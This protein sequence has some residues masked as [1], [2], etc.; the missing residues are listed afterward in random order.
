MSLPAREPVEPP[1]AA[2]AL[3]AP[4]PGNSVRR[5][6]AN[7]SLYGLGSL[8]VSTIGFALDPI[9][10]YHLSLQDFGLL[11]LTASITGMLTVTYTAGLDG[12]AGR[13]FYDVEGDQQARERV[14]GTL[15]A[16]LLA[17]MLALTV[18]QELAGPWLYAQFFDGLPYRPYGRLLAVALLLNGLTAIPRSLWA[19]GE[20]VRRLVGVR[21]AS[22]LAGSATLYALLLAG[23]GPLAV[24]WADVLTPT[25]T[26]AACLWLGWKPLQLAW[27]PRVLKAGLAFGLPMIVHL[28]SHWALNAADRLVIEQLLG[29][30]A[31]GLYSAAYKVIVVLITVNLSINGGYVPQFMRAQGKPDQAGFL[32]QAVTYFLGASA[33]ATLALMALAPTVIR[34]VYAQ[35]FGAAADLVPALCVGAV[36]QGV[37]LIYVNGLFY[38]KVT[39]LIP[40]AT[41]ISG[42]ANVALCYALIPHLG[43]VGAA[44]ATTLSYAL[45]A[46]LVYALCRRI[47]PIPVERDRLARLAIVFGLLAL[48]EG[49]VDGRLPLAAEAAVKVAVLLLAPLLLA[50][51][52]FLTPDEK[53]WIGARLSRGTRQRS[54]KEPP[55]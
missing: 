24:L 45:L 40:V 14:M 48:A 54:P 42:L 38:A 52:G 29:R 7:A 23:L 22:S 18:V 13:L 37:Y 33:A 49:L 6:F 43:L 20:K 46:V 32:A 21:V 31:V 28:T 41:L 44:W 3:P 1:G 55:T 51:S 47:S 9:L 10:S 12:A 27:D 11:G 36:F 17:W 50:A 2:A 34:A 35:K 16:F 25:L 30:D 15:Q 19:A 5:L 26:L 39:K 8:L 53:Q 4:V